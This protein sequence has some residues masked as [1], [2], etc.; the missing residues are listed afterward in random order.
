MKTKIVPDFD[1]GFTTETT[2]V[3]ES[4]FVAVVT[5]HRMMHL[6]AAGIGNHLDTQRSAAVWGG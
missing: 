3:V 2:T 5:T 6:S 1:L 4:R